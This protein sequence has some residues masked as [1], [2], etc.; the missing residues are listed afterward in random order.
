MKKILTAIVVCGLF[1]PF[2]F[3]PGAVAQE[4]KGKS[5]EEQ[6][7]A[8]DKNNDM[9]VSKDEYLARFAADAEKKSKAETRFGRIDKNSDGFLSLEEYKEGATKKNK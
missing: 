6:F 1:L 5:P 7:K 9:K 2:A 3:G 4:K 8:L